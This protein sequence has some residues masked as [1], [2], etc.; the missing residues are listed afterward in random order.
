MKVTNKELYMGCVILTL[1]FGIILMF[2]I[3][4]LSIISVCLL[5][6]IL[7]LTTDIGSKDY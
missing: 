1:V 3:D 6:T 5:L 4:D 2:I 7:Y